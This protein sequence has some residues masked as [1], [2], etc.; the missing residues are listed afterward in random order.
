MSVERMRGGDALR[1]AARTGLLVLAVVDAPTPAL[2]TAL[3]AVSEHAP[4][5]PVA[6]AEP[7]DAPALRAR[8]LLTEEPTLVFLRRGVEVGRLVGPAPPSRMK[9]ALDCALEAPPGA[10]AMREEASTG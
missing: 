9:L 6:L 4:F 10:E 2:F 7:V 8:F 5:V 3:T 1:L